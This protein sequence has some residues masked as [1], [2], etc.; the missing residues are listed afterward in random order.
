[1]VFS[2]AKVT[3]NLSDSTEMFYSVEPRS[4]VKKDIN[5][6]TSDWTVIDGYMNYGGEN[7]TEDTAFQVDSGFIA[8]L[9]EGEVDYYNIRAD[10]AAD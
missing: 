7:H 5:L 4:T 10:T 8:Y 3:S 9:P 2:G 6:D 1:M